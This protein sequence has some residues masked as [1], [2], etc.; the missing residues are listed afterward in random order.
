[1]LFVFFAAQTRQLM[2]IL[3]IVCQVLLQFLPYN[4]FSILT[5]FDRSVEV[6][7][8]VLV[9]LFHFFYLSF[10]LYFDLILHTKFVFNAV[11]LA[12]HFFYF[13]TYIFQ[14]IVDKVTPLGLSC[15]LICLRNCS[16]L[17]DTTSMNIASG[18][19]KHRLG[20][21][22][23]ATIT[24]TAGSFGYYIVIKASKGWH[25]RIDRLAW[26]G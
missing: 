4:L 22:V 2:G 16:D 1:M 6:L 7:Q 14:L 9:P 3:W 5:C 10:T 12:D 17:I 24:H 26:N 19:R 8:H 11:Q 21:Y 25:N 20:H 18:S 15:L 13:I 23:G